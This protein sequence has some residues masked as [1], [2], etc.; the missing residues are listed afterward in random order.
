MR[1]FYTQH[2]QAFYDLRLWFDGQPHHLVPGVDFQG[3]RQS[4]RA[5]LYRQ[6]EE[7]GYGL[8]TRC[9]DN[10]VLSIQAVNK[11]GSPLTP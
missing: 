8:R 4:V 11:D 1:A 7:Y 6:A 9:Q 2:L 5:F 10:D 3:S